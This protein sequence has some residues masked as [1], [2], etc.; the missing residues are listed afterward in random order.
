MAELG[1]GQGLA[2]RLAADLSAARVGNR[3][4]PRPEPGQQPGAERPRQGPRQIEDGVGGEEPVDV[5]E[6]SAFSGE[7]SARDATLPACILT[8]SKAA[9]QVGSLT[10]VGDRCR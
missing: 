4:H 1:V 8:L 2:E 9:F 7:L 5:H 10:Q 6:S 3:E